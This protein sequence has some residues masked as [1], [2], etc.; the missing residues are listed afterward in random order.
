MKVIK[1]K[2]LIKIVKLVKFEKLGKNSKN[3]VNWEISKKIV[4]KSLNLKNSVSCQ[5]EK[6]EKIVKN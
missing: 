2:M 4:K 1:P 3:S 6:F 5:L